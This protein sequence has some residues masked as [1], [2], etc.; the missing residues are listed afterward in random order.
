MRSIGCGFVCLLIIVLSACSSDQSSLE[1]QIKDDLDK[2]VS[3]VSQNKNLSKKLAK[4]PPSNGMLNEDYIA[5]YVW[6]KARSMQLRIAR[7]N[8]L[9]KQALSVEEKQQTKIDSHKQ[10][11]ETSVAVDSEPLELEFELSIDEVAALEELNFGSELYG[12]VRQTIDNTVAFVEST[13]ESGIIDLVTFYDPVIKHNI[14]V[15]KTFKEK[16]QFADSV[17]LRINTTYQ[18]LKVTKRPAALEKAN[19]IVW[20]G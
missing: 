15:V 9:E 20:S 2:V 19:L 16:L 6:V 14:T 4:T 8:G 1:S 10:N 7:I 11:I 5:M 3:K 17:Q 13:S 18:T 12:W